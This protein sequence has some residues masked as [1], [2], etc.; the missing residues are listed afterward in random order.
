MRKR[1]KL[2]FS[3]F[4]WILLSIYTVASAQSGR[5]CLWELRSGPGR[6][7]FLGSVHVLGESDYPLDDVI[8]QAFHSSEKLYFELDMDSVN[9]PSVQQKI[10][11]AGLMRDQ[12]LNE[13]LSES[14]YHELDSLLSELGMSI[15]MMQQ[16]KPWLVASML[17]MAKLNTLGINPRFGIDQY[18]FRR[19]GEAGKST[20][21]MESISDQIRCF[22]ALDSN[23]EEA[24]LIETLHSMDEIENEFLNLKT[25]WK[26]G[27]CCFLDSVMNKDMQAFPA[28]KKVLIDDRNRR[29]VNRVET[30][31]QRHESALIIV[32]SGH[33][34]GEGSLV[35]LLRKKGYTVE[36][37]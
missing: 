7:T 30:M 25:A 10:M 18:F 2:K 27:N 37:L 26:E 21:S 11:M 5:H 34:V 31:I 12:S 35:D 24:L 16:L 15:A 22:N 6:I 19:A 33:L 4:L 1:D 29:W 9:M 13:V 3:V 17:T 32:G 14:V 23:L 36:Q 8:E 28:L 20:G